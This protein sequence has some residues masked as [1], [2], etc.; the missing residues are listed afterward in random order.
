MQPAP[1][2]R[3]NERVKEHREMMI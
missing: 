2:A 3:R 1:K